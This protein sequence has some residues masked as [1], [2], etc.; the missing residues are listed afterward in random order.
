MRRAM[1]QRFIFDPNGNIQTALLNGAVTNLPYENLSYNYDAV[2]KNRLLSIHNNVGNTT[3]NY[4]YDAIGNVTKDEL[5]GN[6][7]MQ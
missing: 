7:Q 1:F 2:K 3:S 5:E 4:A 6:S